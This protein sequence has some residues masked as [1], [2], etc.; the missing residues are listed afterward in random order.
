[1]L[2]RPDSS[3]D[4]NALGN[5]VKVLEE[6]VLQGETYVGGELPCKTSRNSESNN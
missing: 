3:L 6:E 2:E 4:L 5:L 1:M